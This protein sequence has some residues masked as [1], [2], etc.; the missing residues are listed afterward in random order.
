MYFD[1]CLSAALLTAPRN[2]YLTSNPVTSQIAMVRSPENT[3]APATPK[4][5]FMPSIW[6]IPALM[7]LRDF[8]I[9]LMTM[10]NTYRGKRARMPEIVMSRILA[11]KTFICPPVGLYF[12][13]AGSRKSRC[14]EYLFLG[15]VELSKLLDPPLTPVSR[16]SGRSTKGASSRDPE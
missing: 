4:M 16:I 14:K 9:L 5:D 6:A 1:S 3:V 11:R 10:R 8:H 13:I 15:T 7:E 2:E 12:E